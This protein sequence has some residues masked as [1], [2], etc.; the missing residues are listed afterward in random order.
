LEVT[1]ARSKHKAMCSYHDGLA[2]IE[3]EFLKFRTE[4]F[5]N[6]LTEFRVRQELLHLAAMCQRFAEDLLGETP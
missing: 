4:V 5:T 6:P 1:R 3:E 2:V